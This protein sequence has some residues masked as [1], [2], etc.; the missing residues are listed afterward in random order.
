VVGFN[1]PRGFALNPI[2]VSGFFYSDDGGKMF[3]DGGQLPSPGLDTIGATKFPQVFGDPD[4]KYLGACT[5]M[6]SSII[7]K[8]FSASTAAQT[9]GVVMG[10][11]FDCVADPAARWIRFSRG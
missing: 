9:M 3:V 5:F 11:M 4:V 1:E 10:D 7:L 6:Y 2:S 8:K